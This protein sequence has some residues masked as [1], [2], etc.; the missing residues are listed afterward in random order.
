M[1]TLSATLRAVDDFLQ[2]DAPVPTLALHSPVRFDPKLVGQ[3]LQLHERIN[4]R[5]A[6][7][8]CVIDKDV[9]DATATVN[10]CL[11]ALHDLRRREAVRLYPVIAHGVHDDNAAHGQLMQLRM[12]MVA[13]VR[14]I[15][16]S[17]D[18]LLQAIGQERQTR[19]QV[20]R[21]STPLADY[22]R[23]SANEVYPLYTLM[24]MRATLP[25][26]RSA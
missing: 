12:V 14:R 25:T 26:N 9:A 17:F 11:D 5:F 15:G 7:L 21:I 8:L 24:G 19:A 3:L 23:R 1:L 16:R 2:A 4:A 13:L 18:E 20:E 6:H 10:D 22:L